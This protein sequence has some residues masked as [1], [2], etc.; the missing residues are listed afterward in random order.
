[1]TPDSHVRAEQDAIE[2]VQAIAA[3]PDD[4]PVLMLNLNRYRPDC[5]YPEGGDYRAYMGALDRAVV[6]G[7]GQVLWR[8]P[9]T[10]AVI[11]CEHD[12][13]DEILAVWY[14]DHQAFLDL[15]TADGA[16]EM[17]A[18]RARCVEHA[19]ILALPADRAPL[20]PVAKA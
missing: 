7:R 18:G 20:Q 13:Y 11:G 17:F 3:G 9:V 10:A 15:P 12:T 14:P 5:G 2:R 4:G 16:E 19:T 8:T 1:M 6:A